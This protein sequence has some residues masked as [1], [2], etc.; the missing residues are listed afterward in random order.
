M[1]RITKRSQLEYG[2]RY[3]LAYGSSFVVITR[4]VGLYEKEKYKKYGLPPG[5]VEP[6]RAIFKREKVLSVPH[7]MDV[8]NYLT[9]FFDNWISR[10]DNQSVIKAVFEN[11]SQI[12]YI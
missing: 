5:W 8:D 1:K 2:K 9:P 3:L 6:G 4:F 12:G 11:L 7:N 10:G